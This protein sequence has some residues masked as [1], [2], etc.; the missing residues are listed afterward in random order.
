M[1]KLNIHTLF[2]EFI[3]IYCIVNQI[4]ITSMF[5]SARVKLFYVNY[6]FYAF[7]EILRTA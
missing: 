7:C 5:N 4:K 1:Y 3:Y 2:V 6:Y